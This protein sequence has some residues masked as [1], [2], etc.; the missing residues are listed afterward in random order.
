MSKEQGKYKGFKSIIKKLCTYKMKWTENIFFRPFSTVT[1]ARVCA[2]ARVIDSPV[3][4]FLARQRAAAARPAPVSLAYVPAKH[5]VHAEAPADSRRAERPYRSTSQRD[6]R[7]GRHNQ[8]ANSVSAIGFELTVQLK[9]KPHPQAPPFITLHLPS[10]WLIRD[11]WRS[12][13]HV[14]AGADCS[15][16]HQG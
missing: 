13:C 3:K 15:P 9:C 4:L 11:G 12:S 14:T 5:A 2:R 10:T 1:N 6:S 8:G 16:L 7:L